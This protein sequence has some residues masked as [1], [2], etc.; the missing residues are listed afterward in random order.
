MSTQ[1]STSRLRTPRP[2]PPLESGDRLTAEEFERRFDATPGLT[3]AE[4]I[5]GVV[6]M[7]PPVSDEFH[8]EPHFDVIGWLAV[9]RAA[10]PGVVGSDNATLRIDR[11]NRPQPDVALRI[12]PECGGQSS[13]DAEGYLT[14]GPEFV[15]EVAA[16]SASQDL[17][18][19]LDLYRRHQ[20]R[21]YAV[22]RVYEE[23]VDWL[24]LRGDRYEQLRPDPNGR[25]R[26]EVFPGL[27]LDVPALLRGDLAGVIGLLQ[28]GLSSPEH[29]AC[30]AR[31]AA[32]RVPG[33]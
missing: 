27:W 10:T 30:A 16:S 11:K 22:W 26:S 18:T 6:Y 15:F 8:A 31:L 28:Q 7:P 21:E 20:V 25:F 12:L 9:Y 32:A 4:L 1:A 2:V 33:S 17:G 13:R 29:A 14:A 24:V 23:A 3:E 5:D 19:K